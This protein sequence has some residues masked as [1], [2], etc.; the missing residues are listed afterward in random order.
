M[1]Q[2]IN[3]AIGPDRTGMP[4]C[5]N[6]CTL[7]KFCMEPVPFQTGIP[8]SPIVPRSRPMIGVWRGFEHAQANGPHTLKAPLHHGGVKMPFANY[9]GV[10]T[11]VAKCLPPKGRKVTLRVS[12]ESS[13]TCNE[14]HAAGNTNRRSPAPLLKAMRKGATICHQS[15]QVRGANLWV[16]QGPH[17][18][19]RKIV[20]N[21][22]KKIGAS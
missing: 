17:G 4:N 2:L 3:S 10:V 11:G 6:R 1:Q 16:P 21:H 15:I 9:V 20:C 7:P 18:T 13:K 12:P 5:I 22:E 19:K 8:R 14:H